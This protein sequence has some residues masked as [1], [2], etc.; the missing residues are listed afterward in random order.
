[1]YSVHSP[2][3]RSLIKRSGPEDWSSIGIIRGEDENG[4]P[5]GF[6]SGERMI[7]QVVAG[8]TNPVGEGENISGTKGRERK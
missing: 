6:R 5:V 3:I 8:E 4:L 7:S 2:I 1:M